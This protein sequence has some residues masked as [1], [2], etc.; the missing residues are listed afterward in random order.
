MLAARAGV[1][2]EKQPPQARQELKGAELGP[3]LPETPAIL[4]PLPDAEAATSSMPIDELPGRPSCGVLCA[5]TVTWGEV[6]MYPAPR[7]GA[8]CSSPERA[9]LGG[10]S[11]LACLV[12]FSQHALMSPV[13]QPGDPGTEQTWPRELMASRDLSASSALVH[14]PYCRGLGLLSPCPLD[15]QP[16]LGQR[17]L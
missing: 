11:T 4:I 12:W 15:G 1:S 2:Q 5:R 3:D 10:G 16:L 7:R 17:D 14:T 9:R 6:P 8:M 13:C